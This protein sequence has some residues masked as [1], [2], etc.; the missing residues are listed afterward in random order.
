MEITV[1]NCRVAEKMTMNWRSIEHGKSANH[2]FLYKERT[3]SPV[4]QSAICLIQT[5]SLR[6]LELLT[7]FLQPQFNHIMELLHWDGND[8]RMSKIK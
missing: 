6:I 7:H 8:I 4:V 3:F 2:S 5:F 1:E